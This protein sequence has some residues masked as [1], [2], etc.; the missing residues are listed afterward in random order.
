MTRNIEGSTE[1]KWK[2]VILGTSNHCFNSPQILMNVRMV[3]TVV[4]RML[5]VLIILDSTHASVKMATLAVDTQ[6]VLVG[7]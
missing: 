2:Y 1:C 4:L 7:E 5:T 6:P 3:H